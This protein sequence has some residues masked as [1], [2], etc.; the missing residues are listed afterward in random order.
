[1]PKI[2]LKIAA[3]VFVVVLFATGVIALALPRLVH[4][5]DFQ[6]TLSEAAADLLGAPVAWQR[7]ELGILPPRLTIHRPE[8]MAAAENPSGARLAADSIDLDLS[9]LP[10]FL[11]RIEIDALTLSGAEA[12]VTRTS[13]GVLFPAFPTSREFDRAAGATVEEKGIGPSPS[14]P[15][16]VALRQVVIR[17]GRLI[18]NDQTRSPALE[19]RLDDIELEAGPS[20]VAGSLALEMTAKGQLNRKEIGQI[21]ATGAIQVGGAYAFDVRID[22]LLVGA[23]LPY[24]DGGDVTLFD[25]A[26]GIQ[27]GL[28][29]DGQGPVRI[30]AK[31]QL[32][33]G[34][35]FAF[36]GT[37]TLDGSFDLQAKI[38]SL[39]LSHAKKFLADPALDVAGLASGAAELSGHSFSVDSVAFDVHVESGLFRVPDVLVKGPFAAAVKI[40][41]PLSARPSGRI[42]VDLTAAT[43]DYHGQFTK[44]AG[45]RAEMTT[46]FS[47]GPFGERQFESRIKFRDVNEILLKGDLG[48]VRSIAL[49]TPEINLSG[50]SELFPALDGYALDGKL[51]FEAVEFIWSARS[52]SRFRGRIA[53]LNPTLEIP[54]VGQLGLTGALLG[55]GPRLR[56]QALRLTLAGVTF[57]IEGTLDQPLDSGRFDLAI[58]SVGESEANDLFSA[59]SSTSDVIFGDLQVRGQLRGTLRGYV[60]FLSSLEGAVHV[61]VGENGGGRLRGVSILQSMLGEVPFF[62]AL[63]E[64]ERPRGQGAPI[65][66]YFSEDFKLMTGDFGVAEGTIY[67]KPLRLV[68]EGYEAYLTGP[69]EMS[70]LEIAMTGE[71][72]LKE[73]LVSALGDFLGMK[74]VNGESVRIPLAEVSNTL[75]DPKISITAKTIVAI[76]RLLF[77]ATGLDVLGLGL[78]KAL[79]GVL[80]GARKR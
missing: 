6:A 32:S 9:I 21:T 15:F 3:G 65:D 39:D 7:V 28:V 72:L 20:L 55:V 30:D 54:D 40:Q 31:L 11:G 1:M 16:A 37:S 50:W 76:P 38:E 47:T 22:E 42:E 79:G 27:L 13:E 59:L 18:L 2:I 63:A 44:R 23:F 71:V 49:T 68:Y 58:E 8:L 73:N 12:V 45:M 33:D 62:G 35:R 77:R 57:G 46:T 60:D 70:T 64:W 51:S 69:I 48:E 17:D 78:R 19:W 4:R 24:P 75:D 43:V 74:I 10:I 5:A 53:L 29:S 41:A 61:A 14:P 66:D 56:T 25:L 52:P 80:R 36:E 26:A 67:A 34:G